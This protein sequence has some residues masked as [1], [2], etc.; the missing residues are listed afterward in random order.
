MSGRTKR[1]QAG[2]WAYLSQVYEDAQDFDLERGEE[3]RYLGFRPS[4]WEPGD[5]RDPERFPGSVP[6]LGRTGVAGSVWG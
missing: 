6:P 5:P 1:A 3:L 4:K 2:D